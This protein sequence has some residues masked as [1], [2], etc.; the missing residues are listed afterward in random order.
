MNDKRSYTNPLIER[1][2]SS[3]MSH[4]FSPER[5]SVTWRDLWIA[6][7]E[8][9]AELGLP[10]T[11]R[12]IQ[13]MKKNRDNID[14]EYICK[15]EKEIRHDVM[16]HVHDFCRAAP[17]ASSIIHLGATSAYIGDNADVIQIREALEIILDRLTDVMRSLIR[18]IKRHKDTPILSYTHFQPAQPSTMGK[19][20]AL[21][22]QDLQMDYESLSFA[23]ECIKFRGVKGTTGTQDS[24]LKL[25]D[26]ST[27]K[28][29]K[30]DRMV[31]QKMGFKKAFT[32]TG[33]TYPRKLDHVITSALSGFAQSAHKFGNDVR[34]LSHLRELEEPFRDKQVGSSAMAYKKNPMRSER[35]CSLSRF[36]IQSAGNTAY[37][38]ALQW[39]ERTLDDS[40]NRR[41]VIPESFLAADAALILYKNIADG[42]SVHDKIV[43]ARLDKELPFMMTET[44][45]MEGVKAGMD[46][47]KLHEA[48]R[49]YSRE[50]VNE[51]YSGRENDM[52]ERITADPMFSGIVEKLR[53]MSEPENYTGMSAR[54]AER[55]IREVNQT[56]LRRHRKKSRLSSD[57]RV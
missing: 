38:A 56:I 41:L 53:E 27:A 6:L 31:T 52:L 1:Y 47:Q 26:G 25:F 13:A 55:M 57:L 34:L 44:I 19:R 30:L 4:V 20:A 16:A 2:S 48:I 43:R 51:V 22:L 11:R 32:I 12:Q 45:I 39:F 50:A 49:M 37:T 21:W 29:E 33:Q 10:I 5:K 14:F 42:M 23:K 54:Q 24:F 18:F 35:L 15:K 36:I 7:A 40:S 28:V 8:A 3:E 17:E 46:R 9:E